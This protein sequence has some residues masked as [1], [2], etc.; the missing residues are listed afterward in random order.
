M[1]L[2]DTHSHIYLSEFAENRSE[3]FERAEKEGVR[4]ILLPAIDSSTHVDMIG[5]ETANE[6]SCAAMMGVH[7]CSV[8]E[9]FED[10]L[11]IAR[12]FLKKR[13]FIAIG[14]IGLDFY[15][16]K[17]FTEEQYAAFHQ[18]IEWALEFDLPIVI[19]SRNS[20]A[21]CIS[22][23]KEHQKGN[24]KGVFHCFSG[25]TDQAKKIIDLGFFMGIGG[26]VTFKNAGLDKVME[27]INLE[28]I[29]L[30]T[31]APYLAPVPFRGKRNEPSYLKYVVEKLA[32]I[33]NVSIDEIAQITT[34]NAE[35]LFE[36]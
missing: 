22:V 3:I 24:L 8:K 16:D 6:E 20:T 7:P 18:Q 31:D 19:H 23:V 2:I 11:K 4:K 14:E 10:E 34:A 1:K 30:E 29:V 13:R 25:D 32:V 17:T 36:L 27:N 15:W 28:H 33:K 26:V 9:N 35:K 12:D 5:L 21:E